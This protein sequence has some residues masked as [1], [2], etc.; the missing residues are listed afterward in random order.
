MSND[1]LELVIGRIRT[2]LRLQGI[3]DV[4]IQY[5]E[6][7]DEVNEAIKDIIAEVRPVLET[8]IYLSAGE[9]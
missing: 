6:I 2:K 9:G 4:D 1:R 5:T 7:L 3:K 8:V